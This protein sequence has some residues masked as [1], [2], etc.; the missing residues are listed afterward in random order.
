MVYIESATISNEKVCDPIV[1]ITNPS[2]SETVGLLTSAGVA[3]VCAEIPYIMPSS[4]LEPTDV[5]Q[6]LRDY[7]GRPRM[8]FNGIVPSSPASLFTSN[9]SLATL[10]TWYPN[11]LVRLTGVY[12]IRFSLNVVV[13]VSCTPFNQGLI[14]TSFQYGA[15]TGSVYTYERATQPF[16]VEQL[17]HVLMNLEVSNDSTLKIPFLSSLEYFPLRGDTVGTVLGSINVNT[18]MGSP[19]IPSSPDAIFKVYAYLDDIE[20]LG[21]T[22]WVDNTILLNGGLSDNIAD[23]V[24]NITKLV[25]RIGVAD[26]EL[27]KTKVLS[28]TLGYVGRAFS[29]ARGIPLIGAYAGTPA[30]LANTLAKTAASFGYAAPATESAVELKLDRRTLDPTHIDVPMP[31]SK[32]SNFQSNKLAISDA[33]GASQEDQMSFAYVLSKRS[34]IYRGSM[35]TG[36]S[37]NTLLYGTK[38]CP[39]N[40]W[41]RS[42]GNGNIPL[43]AGSAAVNNVIYPSNILNLADHFRYWRGGM[44]FNIEFAKTQFHSGQV[45]ASFIPL[46]ENGSTAVLNNT[47]RVPEGSG[48]TVQPNQYSMLFD[49][50]S[51]TE[52]E[53][54]VPFINDMPYAGVSDSIGS[55]SL[56][57]LNPLLVTSTNCSTTINFVVRVSA[58]P[59]FEFAAPVPPSFCTS[60]TSAGDIFLQSGL[61]VPGN[62]DVANSVAPPA[63][64]EPSANII[65]E[66]FNSLKQLAMIP[67]WFSQTVANAN[68]FEWYIP[69]WSYRPAW[70]LAVPM[71]NPSQLPVAT[72]HVSKV[73]SMFVFSN[74]STRFTFQP[75]G[76]LNGLSATYLVKG[77]PGN[78]N[79]GPY[80][81]ASS[82]RNKRIYQ[83]S[84]TLLTSNRTSVIDA[85]LYSRVQR[86]NHDLFCNGLTPR[87][88]VGG[89]GV[90]L[91][92]NYQAHSMPYVSVRNVSGATQTLF[93]AYAAGEDATATCF[94][95]PSPVILFNPAQVVPPNSSTMFVET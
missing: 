73:A 13:K 54:V 12:A 46:A 9:V 8:I 28:S 34:Q 83:Q 10:A 89:A 19:S 5:S 88:P 35:T 29:T 72:S 51:S 66:K 48:G 94:I 24:S 3:P 20:L 27:R 38:I 7:F 55:F 40:L 44:K 65:G 2:T 16:S 42:S 82:L 50:R 60:T 47:L 74:G 52:F 93:F 58:M 36:N 15:E 67:T 32:L 63:R 95:G 61:D 70:T 85:P 6:D 18:I 49:L 80:T 17:P 68:I 1:E 30:W 21:A 91:S 45:L 64:V 56:V 57:V 62:I 87:N 43:P 41:F 31:A 25:K 53:F 33:M 69:I 4:F 79:T 59:D 22:S 77:N 84:G 75:Q 11:F 14:C 23:S 81:T 78:S 92:T 76:D 37:A 90:P 26:A 86:V 39:M 71:A